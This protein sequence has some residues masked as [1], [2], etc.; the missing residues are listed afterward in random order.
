MK[1]FGRKL[2][3]VVHVYFINICTTMERIRQKG[4]LVFSFPK[5]LSME[6]CYPKFSHSHSYTPETSCYLAMERAKPRRSNFIKGQKGKSQYIARIFGTLDALFA[7]GCAYALESDPSPLAFPYQ[8]NELTQPNHT[9]Q[10]H[11][12]CECED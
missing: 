6:C 10:Y 5:Y 7:V 12:V 1:C 9:Q 2:R 11:S 8:N 4:F 3:E